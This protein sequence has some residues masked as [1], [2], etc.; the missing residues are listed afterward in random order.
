MLLEATLEEVDILADIGVMGIRGAQ[1][2]AGRIKGDVVR[3]CIGCKLATLQVAPLISDG[4]EL[5]DGAIFLYLNDLR[6]SGLV[7][8]HEGDEDI[9]IFEEPLDGGVDPNGVFHLTAVDT[10]IA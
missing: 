2:I 3:L 7:V 5:L 1:R 6:K 8:D 10:A 9:V 4:A